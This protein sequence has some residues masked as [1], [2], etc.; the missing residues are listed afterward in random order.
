MNTRAMVTLCG[1]FLAALLHTRTA[2]ADP[3]SW[4]F[5][6]KASYVVLGDHAR[7]STGGLMPS[8]TARRTFA[9]RENV[10]LGLGAH[11]GAFGLFRDAAWMGILGGPLLGAGYRPSRAPLSFELAAH[12]DFGRVPI[13]NA[14]ALCSRYLGLFPALHLGI[15]YTLAKHL[16]LVAACSV[17]FLRTLAWTG[18]SMEP[19]VAGRFSF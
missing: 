18:I 3:D 10:S 9:L 5:D 13:C 1:P 2:H 16:A 12:L 15:A 8:L 17:R 11:L 7:R 4:Q 6:V 19:A 14:W